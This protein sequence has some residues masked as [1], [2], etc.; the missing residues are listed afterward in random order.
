MQAAMRGNKGQHAKKL[1]CADPVLLERIIK[2]P[3]T[4]L[5]PPRMRKIKDPKKASEWLNGS[6]N[7]RTFFKRYQA[8]SVA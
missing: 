8:I 2:S 3:K 5:N 4:M 1:Y 7:K 6:A